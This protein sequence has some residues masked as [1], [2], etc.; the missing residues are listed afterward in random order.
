MK[1]C[2]ECHRFGVEM[3]EDGKEHCIWNDCLFVNHEN[4]DLDKVVHPI[5]FQKFI[6]VISKKII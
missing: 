6:D 2:P 3:R 1:R 5:R 4:R